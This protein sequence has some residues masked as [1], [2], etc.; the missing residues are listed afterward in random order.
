MVLTRSRLLATAAF[1]AVL[2]WLMPVLASGNPVMPQLAF[3]FEQLGKWD[4]HSIDVDKG[5]VKAVV[6]KDGDTHVGGVFRI[7]M[8]EPTKMDSGRSIS[9]F[10]NSVIAICGYDSLILVA[11]FGYDEQGKLVQQMM[12]PALIED[13][14]QSSTPPTE[15]YKY[16]CKDVKP[17]PA[18]PATP[19]R[20]TQPRG[21]NWT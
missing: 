5:T 9:T 6:D 4:T 14:K 21:N 17:K 19:P 3:K 15:I 8:K 12:G 10:V 13:Y 18:E 2:S 7:V 16:L 1:I 20:N 11:T